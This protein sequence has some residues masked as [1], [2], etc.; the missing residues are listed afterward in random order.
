[1]SLI[2]HVLMAG[3]PNKSILSS[4]TTEGVK[5]N[6][7]F[8][9]YANQG[10]YFSA[11]DHTGSINLPHDIFL[12]EA[13]S[14]M[15]SRGFYDHHE[16]H[17]A[18]YTGI[19][20]TEHRDIHK[21]FENYLNAKKK[22]YDL[23]SY[24]DI[25]IINSD[26]KY[27]RKVTSNC[28][29]QI[30]TF[31][32]N[33]HADLQIKNYNIKSDYS[34]FSFKFLNQIHEIKTFL[35]GIFNLYNICA[36]ILTLYSLNFC[37]SNSLKSIE[38]FTGV[39]GR[40]EKHFLSGNRIA[41]VDYAHTPNSI[42]SAIEWLKLAYKSHKIITV[43][44]CGGDRSE[45]KR[46]IMGK[47][48]S[49][50][51]DYV[52]ITTDN[53]RNEDKLSIINDI[54]SGIVKNNYSTYVYRALAIKRALLDNK[55]SV[56]L[57]AGKG[58]ETYT[59]IIKKYYYRKINGKRVRNNFKVPQRGYILKS[60]TDIL[61]YI[62]NKHKLGSIQKSEIKKYRS[63]NKYISDS[64]ILNHRLRLAPNCY[65]QKNQTSG[66]V[67]LI[68]SP[69]NKEWYKMESEFT[70][71]LKTMMD[72]NLRFSEFKK[73]SDK[74]KHNEYQTLIKNIRVLIRKQLL[75]TDNI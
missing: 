20:E 35:P 4:S 8:V 10:N 74:L 75:L 61:S 3:S 40:M 23:L 38:K 64:M 33:P 45:E 16:H 24:N 1:M 22:L 31:G 48:A 32:V 57:I 39:P 46:P 17:I 21:T 58:N 67:I 29:A 50:L 2:E 47:I 7:K 70:S 51:S 60:D 18:V 11:T 26:D 27:W 25:A 15:L 53:P 37:L 52:Y 56:V 43:F 9:K 19:E 71:I 12:S 28:K 72:K 14:F 55:N 36:A 5:L 62:V 42:K 73:K 13:T 30:I 63:N 69:G 65:F 66:D 34:W 41:I 68:S 59:E 44:G 49:E 54:A 6:C